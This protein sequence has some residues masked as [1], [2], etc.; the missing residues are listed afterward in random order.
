[1]A[2]RK[3]VMIRLLI[4]VAVVL[5]VGSAGYAGSYPVLRDRSQYGSM[6]EEQ[7]DASV[8]R[9]ARFRNLRRR[10]LRHSA[11]MLGA[12]YRPDPLGE[13]AGGAVDTDARFRLAPVDCVTFVEASLAMALAGSL[14]QAKVWMDRLRYSGDAVRFDQ[15]NHFMLASWLPHL[16]EL[17]VLKDITRSIA[18][19]TTLV[20]D[21]D[22]MRWEQVPP[23]YLPQRFDQMERPSGQVE[24][25]L[26]D[27]DTLEANLDAI[28]TGTILL[29]ARVHRPRIPV[30]ISHLGFIVHQKNGPTIFR[31]A[32]QE[33]WGRVVDEDLIRYLRRL[34]ARSKWALQGVNLQ[35]PRHPKRL[36]KRLIEPGTL[37]D[38]VVLP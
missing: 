19:P 22:A 25:P 17:N 16:Q 8:Q 1:M 14:E 4:V 30:R 31:H 11:Q 6:P 20:H 35:L 28:P 3:R 5:S 37:P 38:D 34:D 13:G 7:L 15:R 26:L 32:S 21:Y 36:P 23:R 33:G 2:Q 10:V 27:L 18:E 12:N 9:I 29:L 24:L